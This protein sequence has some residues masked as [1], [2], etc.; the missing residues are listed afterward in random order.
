MPIRTLVP[1]RSSCGGNFVSA[2]VYRLDSPT[3]AMKETLPRKGLR[4]APCVPVKRDAP[5]LSSR[6]AMQRLIADCDS[7]NEL[8]VFGSRHVRQRL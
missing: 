4:H 5:I 7:P 2:F 3:R 6:S 1:A 8:P